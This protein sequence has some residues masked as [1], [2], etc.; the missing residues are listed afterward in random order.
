M[1][2]LITVVVYISRS[3]DMCK[4]WMRCFALVAYRIWD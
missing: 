2:I 1:I 4:K 3:N